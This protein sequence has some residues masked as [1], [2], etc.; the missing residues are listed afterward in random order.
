[1][2]RSSDHNGYDEFD[3]DDF[4]DDNDLSQIFFDDDLGLITPEMAEDLARYMADEWREREEGKPIKLDLTLATALSKTPAKWLDAA[5]IANRI[6]KKGQR[7]TKVTALATKMTDAPTLVEL[8]RNTPAHARA[9]LRKVLESGG[10]IKLNALIKDFGDLEGDGWFWDEIPPTSS[11]GELRQRA[12]L[13]VGRTVL[14]KTG[15]KAYKVAVVPRDLR[16]SLMQILNDPNVKAE[17]EEAIV[18]RFASPDEVLREALEEVRGHFSHIDWETVVYENDTEAFL[19]D[20]H[21]QGYDALSVWQSLEVFLDFLDHQSHEITSLDEIGSYH[22]SELVHEFVDRHYLPRWSLNLRRD[23]LETVERFYK[24]LHKTGRVGDDA[25]TEVNQACTQIRSGKRKLNVIKRPPP[26][27][28]ELILARTNPNT[29]REE[30]YTFN[31]QRILMVWVSECHQDWRHM[32]QV[33]KTVPD[34]HRK[35]E[36]VHDLIALEPST[37]ELLIARA[38]EDDFANGVIWFYKENV[39]ELSAW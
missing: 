18:N 8:V 39:I 24:H 10:W 13:F 37:Q 12:L 11:I 19:L 34:G 20:V 6:S 9:A 3:G 2:R 38:D 29:G 28:G 7:K 21:A 26:L 27:G 36:L 5:C 33:C 1:M 35:A 15:K 16:D 25:L 23:L 22:V 32:L 14:G 30:R 17:E 31:H 4:E